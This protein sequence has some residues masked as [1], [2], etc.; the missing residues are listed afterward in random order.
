VFV[1]T[2]KAVY[3]SIN[4]LSNRPYLRVDDSRDPV[5]TASY[6]KYAKVTMAQ[7]MSDVDTFTG[8]RA[9]FYAADPTRNESGTGSGVNA[10]DGWFKW[11]YARQDTSTDVTAPSAGARDWILIGDDRGFYFYTAHAPALGFGRAGY[12]FTDFTSL[13]AGDTFNT[14]LCAAER[15][16]TGNAAGFNFPNRY[17]QAP[18]EH[19]YSG[20]VLMRNASQLGGA[21]AAAYASLSGWAGATV[22]GYNNNFAFPNLADYSLVISPVLL[23]ENAPATLRGTMPGLFHIQHNQPYPD[24]TVLDNVA[25]YPGRKFLVVGSAYEG[26]TA[27]QLFDLTGPWR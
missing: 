13:K 2:N 19:D 20:K 17:S 4:V 24:R 15:Y 10:V 14:L 11:Y 1:G 7:N 23:R 22:S 18:L 8:P 6:A 5:W 27:S 3:R 25:G 26:G 21:S 16:A 9:P 12:A